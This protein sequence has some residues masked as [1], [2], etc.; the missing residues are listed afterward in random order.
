MKGFLLILGVCFALLAV[1][2]LPTTA[3]A[4]TTNH[5]YATITLDQ[6]DAVAQTD[7]SGGSLF[8][9]SAI[10]ELACWY[11]GKFLLRARSNARASGGWYL[12]R[13]FRRAFGRA[14]C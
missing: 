2:T 8:A 1:F 7:D 6:L 4:G 3:E 9:E 14:G 12:G 13:G 11:P 10:V 5:D